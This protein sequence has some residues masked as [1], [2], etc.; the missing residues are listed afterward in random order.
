MDPVKTRKT[1]RSESEEDPFKVKTGGGS[2]R[3]GQ[4]RAGRQDR[5]RPQGERD[6]RRKPVEGRSRRE[7]PL[8]MGYQIQ[9]L[10]VTAPDKG[11]AGLGINDTL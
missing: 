1:G 7:K 4:T 10:L 9:G 6:E 2:E 8:K 11:F 3:I 5:E